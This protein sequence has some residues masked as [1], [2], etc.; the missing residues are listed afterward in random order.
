MLVDLNRSIWRAHLAESSDPSAVCKCNDYK[1]LTAR[2]ESFSRLV[3][4]SAILY[5]SVH[6]VVPLMSLAVFSVVYSAVQ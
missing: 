2:G 5:F 1:D 3:C 4:H 6:S